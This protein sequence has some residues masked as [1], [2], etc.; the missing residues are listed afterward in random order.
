MLY[1]FASGVVC[2]IALATDNLPWAIVSLWVLV[3]AL[4]RENDRRDPR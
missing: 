2:A 1:V 4:D 3:L